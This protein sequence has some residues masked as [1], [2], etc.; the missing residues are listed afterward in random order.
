MTNGQRILTK[1][2]IAETNFSWWEIF[3]VTPARNK[4]QKQA[5]PA[6]W[7]ILSR[8]CC[9][10][11]L[12]DPFCS[13]DGSRDCL[14]FWM[15]QTIPQN[16][17]FCR[18]SR[19]PSNTWFLGPIQISPHMASRLGQML[20][21]GSQTWPTHRQTDRQT[22]RPHDSVCSNRPLSLAMSAMQPNKMHHST[23]PHM[24]SSYLFAKQLWVKILHFITHAT[25]N[26]SRS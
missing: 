16:C 15:G 2:H 10:W 24:I 14:C 18:R 26:C 6:Y 12:N 23:Q 19:P 7:M 25:I 8:T 9:Y 13:E 17:P 22:N 4:L 21:R 1:G 11:R 5:Y 3:K 20:L